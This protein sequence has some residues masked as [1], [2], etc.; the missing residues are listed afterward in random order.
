[1]HPRLR[2]GRAA[3]GSL[4]SAGV[5]RQG[6]CPVAKCGASWP[7]PRAAHAGLVR[8]TFAASQRVNV[9]SSKA[10][11]FCGR[12]RALLLLPGSPPG[13]GEQAEEKSRSDRRQDAGEFAA[14]TWTYC[15]Q[16]PEPCSRSRRGMDAPATATSRVPFLG[17]LSLGQ[18][19][20]VTRP[21][22]MAGE[23]QQG[24]TLGQCVARSK[25]IPAFA[26]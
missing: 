3:A 12:S 7:A 19:K 10:K 15:P 21:P 6:S 1:M 9:K 14:S 5:W 17:L 24:R 11:S 22:G 18:A 26:E 16:T 4:R 23:A 25:W 13:R 2:A 20:K 8:P